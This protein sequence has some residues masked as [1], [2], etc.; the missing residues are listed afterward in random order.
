MAELPVEDDNNSQ[1]NQQPQS[2]LFCRALMKKWASLT[3]FIVLLVG[4]FFFKIDVTVIKENLFST[5]TTTSTADFTIEN[6]PPKPSILNC[7]SN[8]C[9]VLN[10][11]TPFDP[12]QQSSNA[13]CPDYFRWIHEDLRPWKSTGISRET[14]ENAKRYATFRLAIINGTA[15]LERYH[16]SFQTRDLF[17]LWGILQLLRLY[18]GAV[19]DLELMFQCGDLP[20]IENAD[21]NADLPPPALFQYSGKD[22]A[23]SIIFPDWSYWG[24]VEVNIRPWESMLEGIIEG[25]K[26]K[27]WEDRAPY[28]YWRGNYHVSPNRKDLWKCNPSFFHDWHARLYNQNWGKETHRGFKHS[29]LEDQCTYRY[30]IYVE[31]RSWSVSD[32]YILA[33]DSMTLL[34]KP[35]YYGFF[36]RSLEPMQHYWPIR[37]TNK[38]KD[39][40]FAVDWGTIH[41][42]EAERIGKGGS[43]FVQENLKMEHVYDYML[44]LLREYAKL[45]KFKPEIPKEGV[46]VLCVESMGCN[47]GGLI[48]EFLEESMVLSPSTTLPCAMPP[49]YEPSALKDLLQSRDNATRQVMTWE[50]EY[51]KKRN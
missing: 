24:W 47:E 5:T 25:C 11:S 18:P 23:V 17:T 28:A 8:T 15:Y 2:Q 46:E 39:I 13:T 3:V 30:K 16:R 34:I 37:K 22:S 35:D 45:L 49:P 1:E 9:N 51:R 50:H 14:L 27:K 44:H 31:G 10:G 20:E 6:A 26:K 4:A 38:C 41:P 42:D 40:K 19:P 43:K 12:H 32:K 29:H 21:L 48:R 33:C 7:T 36:L